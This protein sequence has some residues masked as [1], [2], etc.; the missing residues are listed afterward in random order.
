M[1]NHG[2][3]L[4]PFMMKVMVSHFVSDTHEVMTIL[5]LLDV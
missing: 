1:G 2:S 4:Q 3:L 5:V